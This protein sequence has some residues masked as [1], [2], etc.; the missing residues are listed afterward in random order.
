[1]DLVT[2]SQTL[3]GRVPCSWSSYGK[4]L[5]TMTQVSSRYTADEIDS[6]MYF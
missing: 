2:V 3:V 1:V 4:G 5:V 6:S